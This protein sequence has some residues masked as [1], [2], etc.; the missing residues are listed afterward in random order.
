MDP[1]GSKANPVL[2]E[3]KAETAPDSQPP[4]TPEEADASE[5]DA[6]LR[7]TPAERCRSAGLDGIEIECYGHLPDQFWSPATNKRGDEWG[8][9]LDNRLRFNA[10]V[11]NYIMHN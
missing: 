3:S 10:D 2:K 5:K 11:Y 4:T 7:R 1:V 9:D 6:S 8:G